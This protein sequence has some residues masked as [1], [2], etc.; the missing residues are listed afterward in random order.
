MA[1]YFDENEKIIDILN[2]YPETVE[3]LVN[4]GFDKLNNEKY[5]NVIGKI[6]LNLILKTPAFLNLPIN[7]SSKKR[8]NPAE[9]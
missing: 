1:K 8:S 3:L 2:R 5:R 9:R 7:F 4:K 6:S